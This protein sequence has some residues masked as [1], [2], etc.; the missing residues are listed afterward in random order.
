MKPAQPRHEVPGAVGA[1]EVYVHEQERHDDRGHGEQLTD[2]HHVVH[3]LVFVDVGRD[4]H[5]HRPGGEADG[6]G[7]VGDVQPPRDVVTHGGEA[8]AAHNLLGPGVHAHERQRREQG[9]PGVKRPA[10][11]GGD[12]HGVA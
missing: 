10:A 5:H 9:H 4:H 11:V 12:T 3:G 8:H 7:E 2:D 6:E 1:P